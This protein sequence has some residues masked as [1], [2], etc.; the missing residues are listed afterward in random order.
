[1]LITKVFKIERLP[2]VWKW[3]QLYHSFFKNFKK[4]ISLTFIFC[5]SF[6]L[7]LRMVVVVLFFKRIINKQMAIGLFTFVL[8]LKNVSSKKGLKQAYRELFER[9]FS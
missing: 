4:A 9:F 1:M 7:R 6:L 5:C 2:K 8:K 3:I